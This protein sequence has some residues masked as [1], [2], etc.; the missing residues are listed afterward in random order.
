MQL[1]PNYFQL[2]TFDH[3]MYKV[4]GDHMV[5][6]TS[7]C[8]LLCWKFPP[9]M[10]HPAPVV[11]NLVFCKMSAKFSTSFSFTIKPFIFRVQLRWLQFIL[12][13][14]EK[15]LEGI[16][17]TIVAVILITLLIVNEWEGWDV[18]HTVNQL[19]EGCQL[20]PDLLQRG[21][22]AWPLLVPCLGPQPL[23]PE[24]GT[25]QYSTVQCIVQ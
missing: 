10:P 22:E 11:M 19:C 9:F 8:Y 21:E 20:Y 15:H 1:F 6:G 14:K 4:W 2:S 17:I 13:G 5:T 18:G 25:V 23:D 12:Y 16:G 7:Q 3:S 24:G